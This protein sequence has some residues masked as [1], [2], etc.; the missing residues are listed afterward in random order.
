ML[1]TIRKKKCKQ[2][3]K[4]QKKVK[5]IPNSTYKFPLMISIKTVPINDF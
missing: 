1:H 3:K 4:Y 2:H 5:K